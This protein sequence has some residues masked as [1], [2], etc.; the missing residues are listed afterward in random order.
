MPTS[1]AEGPPP[2]AVPEELQ[3]DGEEEIKPHPFESPDVRD[4]GSPRGTGPDYPGADA[5]KHRK[6]PASPTQE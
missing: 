2:V 3:H 5:H 4:Q 6:G 1:P